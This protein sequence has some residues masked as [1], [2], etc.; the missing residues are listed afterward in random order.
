MTNIKFLSVLFFAFI[1]SYQLLAQG[2]EEV[3]FFEGTAS[4]SVQMKG[5]QAEMLKANKPNNKL[6]MHIK[7]GSY[8]VNLMGGEY[9][10]TFIFVADSNFEY[11][12]DMT[13]RR[14]YRFSMHS[15]LNKEVS[16]QKVFAKPTG[17]EMEVNGILCQEYR[18]KRDDIYFTYYVNDKYRVNTGF[19][20]EN[21]R[22]K[23]SF[24]AEGLEG[25][26]PLKTIKQQKG[27]T[28]ITELKKITRREFSPEQFLI[29]GDFIVKNR[30]YRY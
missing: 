6:Q 22:A 11:S 15:D 30:D 29:P 23:A 2:R 20:P 19:Y 24:L 16:E 17:K 3:A 14:A 4:F 9:P 28:V 10:K 26:I 7:D 8:I 12:M 25:R 1:S 13:N 21:S 27:L 18:L 5:P